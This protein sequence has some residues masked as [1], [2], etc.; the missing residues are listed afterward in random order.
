MSHSRAEARKLILAAEKKR[1]DAKAKIRG[2][3]DFA[4]IV[5]EFNA[6]TG[7]LHIPDIDLSG[8][9]GKWNEA[10][11]K[12]TFAMVLGNDRILAVDSIPAIISFSITSR[13]ANE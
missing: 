10:K 9:V 5:P 11:G 13:S 2:V 6:K 1:T 4:R 8:D 12:Y 7:I 3:G